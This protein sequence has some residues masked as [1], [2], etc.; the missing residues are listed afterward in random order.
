[1]WMSRATLDCQAPLRHCAAAQTQAGGRPGLAADALSWWPRHCPPCFL[2]GPPG[3]LRHFDSGPVMLCLRE[4]RCAVR[5]QDLVSGRQSE[6]RMAL[7]RAA[8][9]HRVHR[10]RPSEPIRARSLAACHGAC[11]AASSGGQGLV[12]LLASLREES[13]D[14]VEHGVDLGLC[15]AAALLAGRLGVDQLGACTLEPNLLQPQS[16]GWEPGGKH[17]RAARERTGGGDCSATD[18]GRVCSA[19]TKLP[20]LP[21]LRSGVTSTLVSNL[22]TISFLS[23]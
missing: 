7:R 9:L 12:A 13:L 23:A 21:G 4:R 15:L 20:V 14:L 6:R 5:P 1:M 8:A 16:G 11:C 2:R 17:T 18:A 19:L 10:T 22:L 3:A